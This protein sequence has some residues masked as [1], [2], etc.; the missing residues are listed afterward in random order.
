MKVLSVCHNHPDLSPGGAE[1]YAYELFQEMRGRP[2]VEA[3]FMARA[4]AT[5]LHAQNKLGAMD[6]D[7]QQLLV[8]VGD[9]D[10]FMGEARSKTTLVEHLAD[11]IHRLQPDVVHFQHT[12]HLGYDM[13]RMVRAILPR[14]P[15][16][17][18]LHEMVPICAANG[19][20]VRVGTGELCQAATP[21]QCARC[22]PH[23]VPH[24]F[25][26]RKRFIQQSLAPVD[27]FLAPSEF[28]RQRFI[29]W[30]IAPERIR[31]HDYGRSL[32]APT[33][34]RD[35]PPGGTRSSFGF[36]GQLIRD[37][38]LLPLLDA[39]LRLES[40][41]ADQLHLFLHGA[42]LEREPAA[43]QEAF[44]Q[45]LDEVAGV[46]VTMI[47]EYRP[48]ELPK[49]MRSIDWVVVPSIW[50]ENSPLV[51]QEAFMHRRPVI[52]SDIGGMAEKV[53]HEVSGLHFRCGDPVSL[54]ATM[55]RAAQEEGLWERLRGGV[56]VIPDVR[57]AV[58]EHL[59]FY[60][61]LLAARAAGPAPAPPAVLPELEPGAEHA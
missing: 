43:F 25:S 59:E 42:N 47:G 1:I 10:Y 8:D 4:Q 6:G 39:M 46:N 20:M 55:L 60:R 16:L 2:D 15:I 61:Q 26:L 21:R 35:L 57:T 49:L 24:R 3:I 52:T 29:E 34:A 23:Q 51:I 32:Q 48:P 44:R 40:Q 13:V 58:D 7:P 9:F 30:G 22:F 53:D 18:T 19:H 50:W 12:L 11:Y 27:L 31:L 17:Y 28:L 5:D 38:G 45:R 37:K 36:F 56:P 41:G 33:P 54:A 14:T